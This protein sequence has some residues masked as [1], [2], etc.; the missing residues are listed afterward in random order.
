MQGAVSVVTSATR[1]WR[2]APG[3]AAIEAQLRFGMRV[4]LRL[5]AGETQTFRLVGEDEADAARG[6][7]G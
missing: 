2:S 7:L 4:T 5:P 1:V 6:L 3:L